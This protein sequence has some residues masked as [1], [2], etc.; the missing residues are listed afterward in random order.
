M[1]NNPYYYTEEDITLKKLEPWYKEWSVKFD[2]YEHSKINEN[3]TG[4]MLTELECSECGYKKFWFN[5]F[6]EIF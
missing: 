5:K 6:N 4:D 2:E 1:L 3:F